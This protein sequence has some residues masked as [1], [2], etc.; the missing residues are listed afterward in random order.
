MPYIS[1]ETV[2]E[3][4]KLIRKSFPDFKI[5]VRG[6]NYSSIDVSI[7]EGPVNMLEGSTDTYE[8]VN[9]FYIDDHYKDTPK[10]RKVLK[11][12]YEIIN[13]GNGTECYDG[14]Y[15]RIPN[16]YTHISIGQWNKPYV[17]TSKK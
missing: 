11:K 5:S 15:G 10:V 8:Q 17:V 14:D 16:F 2:K 1:P 13:S 4:R 12:I 9:H 7:L 6:S 3:K